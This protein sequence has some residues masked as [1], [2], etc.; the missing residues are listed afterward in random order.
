M[1]EAYCAVFHVPQGLYGKTVTKNEF[2]EHVQ[3]HKSFKVS[4]GTHSFSVCLK[5]G[6]TELLKSG[7]LKG[8]KEGALTVLHEFLMNAVQKI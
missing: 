6:P 1:F 7:M 8:Q 3:V 4:L 5:D 2:I